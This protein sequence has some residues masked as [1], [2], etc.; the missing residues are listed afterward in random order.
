MK[1]LVVAPRTVNYTGE[2]YEFPLGLAYISA[3]LKRAGFD[4]S[5]LNLNHHSEVEKDIATQNADIIFTGGLSIHYPQ[6]ERVLIMSK[7]VG[8]KTVLGGGI[9]SSN[10]RLVMNTLKPDYGVLFEGEET[11][12]KLAT[13]LE[14]CQDVKNVRGIVYH[15][16]GKI[17]FTKPRKPISN[18]QSI[19]FADYE[20][21][22]ADKY[23]ELQMTNDSH[24]LYPFDYPRMLP[25]IS[26]R[27]CPYSCTFCFHPLGNKYRVRSLDAFFREL[28][29]LQDRFKI[30]IAL[31][32]DELFALNTTRLNDFVRR[33][34]RTGLKWITQLRV[35]AKLTSSFMRKLKESGCICL[36]YGLES[37]SDTILE[38]MKKHTT[39]YQMEK[40][41]ELTWKSNIGIQGNF[42][43]G[44]V[45][46]SEETVGETLNWYKQHRNYQVELSP[47]YVYAGTYLYEVA[48][49][50]G[51]VKDEL[52]FQKQKYPLVN[53]SRL[54][55]KQFHKLQ[56][57]LTMLNME[58]RK[59]YTGRV[60][61]AKK[62]G[63]SSKGDVYDLKVE[64]PFCHFINH[65]GRFNIDVAQ[66]LSVA[67]SR[68][69]CRNCNQRL[70]I[71]LPSLFSKILNIFPFKINWFASRV[72]R[73][74]HQKLR[75]LKN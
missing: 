72:R 55:D 14:G 39:V 50:H 27:S 37:A 26:S 57:E 6:I 33:I 43:F 42:I 51:L 17:C 41:L 2:Y 12:V 9:L 19:P 53:V 16:E 47:I 59:H 1:C 29:I 70:S 34:K 61:Q 28:G 44:D 25:I 73:K 48:K 32:Y 36:G 24:F 7:K 75:G 62:V 31:V 64:C 20:G 5:C 45:A 52:T 69:A 58:T 49:Q 30:N 63:R 54:S 18:L 38:S 4:V 22:E 60:L 10:P 40:A 23:L 46:E 8:A 65:Y 74:F 56:L 21:L 3:S 13:T 67:G 71:F 11:V 66:T 35:D 15:E 68:T